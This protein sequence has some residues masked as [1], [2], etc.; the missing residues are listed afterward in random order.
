ME[1]GLRDAGFKVIVLDKGMPDD[2]IIQLA[3]G[4]SIMTKNSKDFLDDAVAGDYDVISLDIIKFIDDDKTRKNQTV[5]KIV[6]AF[7]D[8][9]LANKKGNFNLIV[10]DNGEHVLKQLVI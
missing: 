1:H 4:W 9:G 8:S 3:E 5:Q 2:K 10:K 7:R 6:K